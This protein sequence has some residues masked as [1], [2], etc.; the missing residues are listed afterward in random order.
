M[1]TPPQDTSS[2]LLKTLPQDLLK[3]FLLK[4]FLKTSSRTSS[5]P[6]SSRH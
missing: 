3:N 1:L 4:N 6:S 2:H 5:R